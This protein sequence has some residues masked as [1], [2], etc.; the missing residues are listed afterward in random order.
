MRWIVWVLLI[1]SAAVGLAMLMR[2]NHGNVAVFWPPYRLDLSVNLSLLLLLLTFVLGH[3]LLLALSKAIDLPTRVRNYQSQRQRQRAMNA[4][5]DSLLAFFEGRFGR[6]ERLAQ[7][8]R[9]EADLAGPAALIAARAA[10]RMR[11]FE[12][13]D[14]WL[15]SAQDE[16]NTNQAYL[17][18]AAELAVEEQNSG[19]ALSLIR[20]LHSRGARHIHTLR[21]ALRAHEQE[22]DWDTVLQVVRQ[23]EKRDALHPA[24]AQGVR[25]RAVRGLFARHSTDLAGLKRLWS[26]LT[27]VEREIPEVT[28]TAAAAIA[29]AGDHEFAWKLIEQGLK[30]GLSHG[31]LQLFRELRAIPARERI[32][33]AETWRERFGDDPALMLTLASLCV[34]ESLWG[35]AEEFYQRACTGAEAAQAHYGLARLYEN[36]GKPQQAADAF[37]TAASI[38]INRASTPPSLAE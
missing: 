20:T 8:V 28:E 11:E 25:L 21:L 31:L 23:L 7:Q 36:T 9:S 10:H 32:L 19:Q 38:A 4:M 12:R 14:K 27:L 18:T 17:V 24:A 37:R 2:F 5:R 3:L 22:E 26:N 35:K 1:F 6:A 16:S 29:Q 13:R 33:R 15:S 34:D 30:R